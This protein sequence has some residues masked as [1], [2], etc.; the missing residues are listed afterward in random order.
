MVQKQIL[1]VS[2]AS[3]SVVIKFVGEQ[4]GP[5]EH[6]LKSEL[7]EPFRV[8]PTVA[9]AHLAGADY[10]GTTGVHVALCMKSSIGENPSLN[11]KVANIFATLFD[12][13]AHLGVLLIREDQEPE[14]LGKPTSEFP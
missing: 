14:R 6:D 9:R 12:S 13:R 11:P 8:E 5:D 7:I 3:N 10:G 1:S 2:A 4:D